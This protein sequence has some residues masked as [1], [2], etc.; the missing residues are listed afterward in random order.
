MASKPQATVWLPIGTVTLRKEYYV[1][2]CKDVFRVRS[3]TP[4]R[5][6]FGQE[7]EGSVMRYVAKALEGQTV[8]V[9]EAQEVLRN[10]ELQLPYQYGHK[11]RYYAQN[12]L[13]A[14]VADGKASH[15]KVGRRFEYH[16]A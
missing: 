16:L 6:E 3:D 2:R 14:L 12:V 4:E 5:A 8:T 11:Q 10:S 9:D 1:E 15:T 7:V 13:V